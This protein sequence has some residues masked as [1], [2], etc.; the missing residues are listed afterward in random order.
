LGYYLCVHRTG[1]PLRGTIA[2]SPSK[3]HVHR[4]LI[5]GSL[6]AGTTRV[7]GRTGAEHVQDTIRA[8]RELGV[9][10]DVTTDGY[11]VR[12]GSYRPSKPEISLGSSGSTAYFLVGLCGRSERGPVT[13]TAEKQLRDRPISALLGGLRDLGVLLESDER[14]LPVTVYPGLPRGGHVRIEG[15]LS[16]QVSGLLMVAPLAARDSTIEIVGDRNERPYLELTVRM[17]RQFGIAIEVSPDWRRFEIRGG[18]TYRPVAGYV[19]PSDVSSAAYGIVAA[20]LHPSDVLFTG[21]SSCDDHPER[22]FFDVLCRMGAPL[23]FADDRRTLRIAHDG[24]RLGGTTIDCAGFPDALPVLCVAAALA[25][26]RTVLNN[27]AHARRKESDRVRA[28]LQLARMGARIS[29]T[30]NQIVVDGVRRLTGQ[31]LS[32]YND[33]RVLMSLAIAGTLADGSTRLTYPNA[34]R[35]SYPGFLA[36][37][38]RIGLDVSVERAWRPVPAPT[39][40]S[41]NGRVHAAV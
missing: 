35:I 31:T 15:A 5:L 24:R 1:A 8:L 36:D 14:R 7:V 3:Y 13:L 12:G 20:A 11:V 25:E 19:V 22:A 23:D 16:Q 41:R 34:F 17:L 40:L 38:N 29:A 18:Q 2:L 9:E 27:V 33:H 37:M 4:A 32:S 26:G 6:A 21:V 10:V 28:S 30:E 39:S